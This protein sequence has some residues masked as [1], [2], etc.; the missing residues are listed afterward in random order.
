MLENNIARRHRSTQVGTVVS[1]SGDK[2]I[3]VEVARRF[4]HP[5]YKRYVQRRKKYHVHDET[6]ECRVGDR[7]RIVASRPLSK[8]KRWRMQEIVMASTLARVK[9]KTV[10]K[11]K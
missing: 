10:A 9:Q 3:V 4:P 6:N 8:T 1:S 7:V 2:T 5:M 11:G